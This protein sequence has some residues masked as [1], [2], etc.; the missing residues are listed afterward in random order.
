MLFI[1]NF[2]RICKEKGTYPTTVVAEIDKYSSKLA[3]WAKGSLPKEDMLIKLADHLGCHV[4]DFFLTDTQLAD[5][6][7]NLPAIAENDDE[8]DIL[9]FYRNLPRQDKHAFMTQFYNWKADY[10]KRAERL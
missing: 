5:L 10:E 2:R 6:A 9:D 7:T 3:T 1:N 8:Q 4:S